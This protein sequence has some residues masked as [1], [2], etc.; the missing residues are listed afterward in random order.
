MFSN[1]KIYLTYIGVDLVNLTD[2]KI[3]RVT[4]KNIVWLKK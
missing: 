1:K 3:T 2:P 4:I